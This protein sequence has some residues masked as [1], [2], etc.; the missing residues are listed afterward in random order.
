MI[1]LLLQLPGSVRA[2][3]DGRSCRPEGSPTQPCCWLRAGGREEGRDRCVFVCVG[4]VQ[5]NK[6]TQHHIQGG[7]FF[8]AKLS[9]PSAMRKLARLYSPLCT[10]ASGENGSGTHVL[11]A[12][13]FSKLPLFS[14]LLLISS[15]AGTG[16]MCAGQCLLLSLPGTAELE[17]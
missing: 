10:A 6:Q 7:I 11:W 16:K 4:T 17:Q 13:V 12:C 8:L 1:H 3:W 9:L 5:T 14:C 15:R 2:C